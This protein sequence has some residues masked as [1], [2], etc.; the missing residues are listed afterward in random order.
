M[1]CDL[2]EFLNSLYLVTNAVKYG[3]EHTNNVYSVDGRRVWGF[4]GIKLMLDSGIRSRGGLQ[5]VYPNDNP[6]S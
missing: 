5:R 4:K 1:P 2:S 6:F 3:I